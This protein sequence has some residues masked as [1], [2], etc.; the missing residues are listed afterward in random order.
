MNTIILGFFQARF[1]KN[2]KRS[3]QIQGRKNTEKIVED[4]EIDTRMEKSS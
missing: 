2:Y 1:Q 3:C 4:N